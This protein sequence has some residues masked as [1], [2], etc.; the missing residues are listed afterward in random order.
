MDCT[1]YTF[2]TTTAYV[3]GVET[4][5]RDF[6]KQDK[7]Y[8]KN[9][10]ELCGCQGEHNLWYF[11]HVHAFDIQNNVTEWHAEW[12]RHFTHTE[13]WFTMKEGQHKHRRADI[14]E[15][16]YVLEIQHSDISKEEVDNRNHDYALHEKQVFWVIDGSNASINGDVLTLDSTWKWDSFLNCEY[17]YINH[18]DNV[19]KISPNLVKSLTVHVI[20]VNKQ[21]WI[22]SIKT[23]LVEYETP[24]QHTIYLKQQGAGNG[25][26]WGIIKMLAR[27]DFQHYKRFIY[28]T[29][30]HSARVILKDELVNQLSN[31]GFTNISELQEKNKKFIIHY[32]NKIGNDC[33][34]VIATIDS[35][36]YAVGDKTVNSFDMFPEIAQSIK[37]G[38][39]DAD[40]RGKIQYASINPKLN[41]ETLYI[42]DE[43]QDLN[44]CYAHAVFEI[45][46]K[47]NMDIY[48]V[49]DKLQSISNELN[50]FTT[51]QNYTTQHDSSIKVYTEDTI[52]VCRRFIHPQLIDFI[53]HM[54]PFEKY[55]LPITTPYIT[56][57][58]TH[59]AVFPILAK[60]DGDDIIEDTVNK[61]IH[62]IKKE[63]HEHHYCPEN[64]LIVFPV[65]SCNPLANMLEIAINE[66]WIEQIK[67]PYY[68][69]IPYWKNHDIDEY[70]RYCVFHKSQ[71]GTSIN[72]DESA[73]AT[74]MVSI[75]SS[76]GDGR[77]VVFVV[78]V[79]DYL[80]KK[81][82]GIRDTLKY[83]SLLYVALTRMKNTLYIIYNDDEIGKN[84]KLWLTKTNQDVEVST[85]IIKNSI[86]TTEIINLS[87]D[88]LNT[89]VQLDFIKSN[90]TTQLIDMSH[91]NIR[92]GILIETI[93]DLLE[94]EVGK[95]QIKT[96]KNISCRTPVKICATW[97]EYNTCI[98]ENKSDIKKIPL[99]KINERTYNY[100]LN[101]I[102]QYIDHICIQCKYNIKL[103]PFELIVL[104]YMN[105]ITQ[106][107]R[108]SKITM[109]EL[110]NIIDIYINA[111]KHHFEGH[112][113][114]LCKK[115][116]ADNENE[117]KLTDYLNSHYEQMK[118]IDIIFKQI[119]EL[120]PNTDWNADH[121][122]KY[123]NSK[124]E[125]KSEIPFI[126]YNESNVILCYVS[127][128]L[129][130]MNINIFKTR[131][132]VDIF[133][134][135]NEHESK[136]FEKYNNKQIV[137]T[138]IATNLHE[139]YFMNID[140]DELQV[141][142][143]IAK[144]MYDHYEV[145]NNEMYNFYKTYRKKYEP[146]DFIKKCIT[147]WLDFKEK[148]NCKVPLYIDGFMDDLNRQY[149][150]YKDIH[151]FLKELDETFLKKLNEELQYSIRDFLKL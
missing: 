38:H 133:I 69:T 140:V 13:I 119:K 24:L 86:N 87:G 71:E 82:S 34:I 37:E 28:G 45:M 92:F 10:H 21:V 6:C 149:R 141:K 148:N 11:R 26:T 43:A 31:L 83:D 51:F 18:M 112:D 14:V 151:V 42:I 102:R 12:Q 54:T 91:H 146:K 134:I 100:Y 94:D 105:Q 131:A 22:D 76:K 77:E 144:S 47:T 126:G 49:G 88:K 130:Q 7:A 50:A 85:I 20:P 109:L 25:K 55:E 115:T 96:Q 106:N 116:F 17:I 67:Q 139:P 120:Y 80:L 89:L 72:L 59:Q 23:Q 16:N 39:L 121:H 79:S 108:Y 117:N 110:Y 29:K 63:V 32:T 78:G 53:N 66:F 127:P 118:Q 52:N 122:I 132:I 73:H 65:V 98:K 41:A 136:N 113:D 142:E 15:G 111:F 2:N 104:Y 1:T 74:R 30:Q 35:F 138:I 103:C 99:L 137:V 48:V 75:H 57:D 129:D 60:K 70:Y 68:K 93:R 61:I 3:N 143:I 62:E 125:I 46:K 5:I 101:I 56:C 19:Y 145:R 97:Y 150:K 64:F 4:S 81:Y 36:M 8:C 135:K 128:K 40:V 90:T 9:G 27:D 114:C 95:Q 123:V 124:F 107:H 44:V 147:D 84:I 33:S 58:D